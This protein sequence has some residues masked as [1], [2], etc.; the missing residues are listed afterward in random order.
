MQNINIYFSD[1]KKVQNL[2]E[3]YTSVFKIE[4]DVWVY[5]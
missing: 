3:C 4:H 5:A 2:P 1:K